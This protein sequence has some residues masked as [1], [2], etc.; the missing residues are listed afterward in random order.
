MDNDDK[1]IVDELNLPW[2]DEE[3]L[4][5]FFTAVN[6]PDYIESASKTRDLVELVRTR[7]AEEL[8]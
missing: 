4:R 2:S 7:T 8:F 6:A 1:L 3:F 5:A